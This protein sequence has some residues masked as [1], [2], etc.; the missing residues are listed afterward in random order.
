MLRVAI[1]IPGISVSHFSEV[2]K[3]FTP[4]GNLPPDVISGMITWK[5]SDSSFLPLICAMQ[6]AGGKMWIP[7]LMRC[8][9]RGG[10]VSNL[11]ANRSYPSADFEGLLAW[12]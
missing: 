8:W 10:S 7:R 4:R 1:F 6:F 9:E 12:G 5:S 3:R 2:L 11:H